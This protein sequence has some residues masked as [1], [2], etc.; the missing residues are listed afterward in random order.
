MYQST[1]KYGHEQGFSCA[2]RQWR[3][4]SHCHLMHGYAL[5]FELTF[6]ADD[7]DSRNWVQDFGSLKPVKAYLQDMFDHTYLLAYDDPEFDRIMELHN[8][9]L[10][11]VRPVDATGCEATAKMVFDWAND[12]LKDTFYERVRLVKVQCWE[13]EGNSASYLGDSK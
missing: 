6:E 9:K 2:F 11:D 5:A 4:D 13:H 3:A 1:K 10:I 8:H 12:W 7:L